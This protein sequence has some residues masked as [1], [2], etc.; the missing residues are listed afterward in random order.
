MISDL[1]W[2]KTTSHLSFLTYIPSASYL[3][4][5]QPIT[6]SGIYVNGTRDE[7]ANITRVY[8]ETYDVVLSATY[9]TCPSQV[10]VKAV[11]NF[12]AFAEECYTYSGNGWQSAFPPKGTNE[13]V[14]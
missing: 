2:N 5:T 3:E 13:V 9:T 6:F 8:G 11:T 10:T 7:S 14:G 12:G 4:K 1:Q